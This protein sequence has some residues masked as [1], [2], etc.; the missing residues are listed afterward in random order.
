M[1]KETEELT[2]DVSKV[3]PDWIEFL[4]K[5]LSAWNADNFY[6]RRTLG[7][8]SGA[9]V[10]LVEIQTPKHNGLAILKL[11]EEDPLDE[12]LRRQEQAGPRSS[13]VDSPR[14]A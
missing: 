4:N 8:K 3:A 11:S 9:V 12:E 2:L 14:A 6:I 1:D 13:R 7:G 5:V 10:M